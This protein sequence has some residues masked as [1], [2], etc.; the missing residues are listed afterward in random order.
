MRRQVPLKFWCKLR[1]S[2]TLEYSYGITVPNHHHRPNIL[3]R[4][5]DS[6]LKRRRAVTDLERRNLRRHNTEHPGPQS[7][8]VSWF[9]KEIGHKI[10]TNHRYLRSSPL[11]TNISTITIEQIQG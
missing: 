5:A 1:I 4:I 7:S 8:L 11:N 10:K 3:I 6:N 2:S 9:F